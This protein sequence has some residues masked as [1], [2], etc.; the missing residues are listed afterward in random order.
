MTTAPHSSAATGTSAPASMPDRAITTRL[1]GGLGNQLFQYCAGRALAEARN[2][3]LLLD[4]RWYQQRKDRLFEL[5][6]FSHA[7]VVATRRQL[8]PLPPTHLARRIVRRWLA[9]TGRLVVE[10]A[11][12]YDERLAT[13]RPGTYLH[14]YWQVPAYFQ[15]METMLRDE[16][17]FTTL[18]SSP[19]A[20][21]LQDL[22]ATPSISVHIRRGDYLSPQNARIFA[23]CNAAYYSTAAR[24]ILA[25]TGNDYRFVIF[26]D[27]P[28]WAN[29]NIRLPGDCVHVDWNRDPHGWEDMRLMSACKHHII[30]NSTFSWWGAWLNPDPGKIVV[31]PKTWY[32]TPT[33][34]N[35]HVLPDG[36]LR[37]E[38]PQ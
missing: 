29:D 26:S 19:N 24:T 4:T 12:E 11:N 25:R 33:F 23:V 28:D 36:W 30:A 31:S 9:R 14:G 6:H 1:Q 37:I 7:G 22:K 21:M 27:D 5:R 18:P 17:R 20:R 32:V 15:H 16:L 3:P 34:S 13:A 2:V 8:P 35:E 38:N 10:R